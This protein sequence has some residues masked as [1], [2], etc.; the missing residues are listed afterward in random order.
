MTPC[1]DLRDHRDLRGHSRSVATKNTVDTE[2]AAARI[3]GTSRGPDSNLPG[4]PHEIRSLFEIPVFIIPVPVSKPH[5]RA[6]T[7][8]FPQHPF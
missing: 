4:A 7:S 5:N 6:A 3:L 1:L 2:K 8:G